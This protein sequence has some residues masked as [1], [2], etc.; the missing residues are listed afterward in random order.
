ME[1]VLT[2]EDVKALFEHAINVGRTDV[3]YAIQ[4][5]ER[6][7]A[8][9]HPFYTP[10]AL[11]T[12]AD[13]YRK[14]GKNELE[15]GAYGRIVEM[16]EEQRKL[17]NPK[18]VAACYVKVGDLKSADA[19][20]RAQLDLTRDDPALLAAI[21]ELRL[22]DGLFESAE[23]PAE[24][25]ILRGEPGYQVLGRLIKGLSLA[26]RGNH[27]A[28]MQELQL[29]GQSL[30]ANAGLG[31]VWDYRDM[32]K[33]AGKLGP[34]ARVADPLFRALIA[35]TPPQDFARAWAELTAPTVT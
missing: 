17:L 26:L 28:A 11:S 20:L 33:F 34:S 22:F 6:V 23:A 21:G 30:T 29:V 12:L 14:L 8:S 9:G 3:P 4:L 18:F 27:E 1:S 13:Q 24:K 31:G 5:L 10:F 7:A 15:L 32:Q 25:L 16:P 2:R 35:G 19:I